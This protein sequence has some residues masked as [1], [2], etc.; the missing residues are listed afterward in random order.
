MPLCKTIEDEYHCI[1]ECP[2][3]IEERKG[4]M[5]DVPRKRPIMNEFVNVF[6]CSNGDH[7]KEGGT[8]L[9]QNY[10]ET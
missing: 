1:V 5:T 2:K 4:C 7:F 10:E 6:K 9:L 8:A 3:Y